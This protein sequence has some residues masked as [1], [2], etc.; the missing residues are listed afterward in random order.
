MAFIT[1]D[2]S[3]LKRFERDLLRM[4]ARAYPFA[5]KFALNT[6]VFQG[7]RE[8]VKEIRSSMIVKNRWTT[9]KPLGVEKVRTLQVRRQVAVLGHTERYMATQEFGGAR[10]GKRHGVPLTTAWAA[11]QGKKNPRTRVA[12]RGQRDMASIKLTRRSRVGGQSRAKNKG[13]R[14]A[15][16]VGAA[17]RSKRPFVFL[18]T[19]RGTKGIFHVSGSRSNP[20][21]WLVHDMSR[22]SV[23]IPKR[24]WLLPAVKRVQKR[25]PGIYRKELKKQLIRHR[26]FVRR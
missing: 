15:I 13:Q 4:K 26:L 6:A 20:E 5:T 18:E 2:D 24:P 1:L 14:T 8:A 7:R 17:L 19:R 16:A 12:L 22:K 25:M 11:G 21:V 3:E 23:T 9:G 10:V